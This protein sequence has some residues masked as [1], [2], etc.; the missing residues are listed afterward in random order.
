MATI[1]LSDLHGNVPALEAVLDDVARQS[2]PVDRFVVLG[3]A[4]PGPMPVELLHRLRSLAAPTTFLRGNGEEDV[5]TAFDSGPPARV[6]PAFHEMLRW[7][8]HRL[9]DELRDFLRTWP[10]THRLDHPVLGRVLFCHATPAD[11]N[12]VFTRVTPEDRLRPIF[13]AADADLV[14]C[15]HTHLPFDRR[16]GE[17]RIVN[18]GSVG[19]PFGRPGADWLILDADGVHARHTDYDVQAT[20]ASFLATGCPAAETFEVTNPPSAEEMTNRLEA[21][22][23]RP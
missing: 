12:V 10:L 3:D 13:D 14:V 19:M 17:T 22:A 6:P 7:V 5:L 21:V 11:A 15:G 4:L 16:V 18:A 23:L 2:L 20:T 9:P 8:A 1:V